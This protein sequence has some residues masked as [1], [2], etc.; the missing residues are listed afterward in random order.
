MRC[1]SDAW[2][3]HQRHVFILTLLLLSGYIA[4]TTVNPRHLQL[5]GHTISVHESFAQIGSCDTACQ[6]AAKVT[7]GTWTHFGNIT[8]QDT[9]HNLHYYQSGS[10]RGIRIVQMKPI[11]TTHAKIDR[12]QFTIQEGWS[13][14]GALVGSQYWADDAKVA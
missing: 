11:N 9:L 13:Q 7:D 2:S 12:R 4:Y 14:E 5:S 8:V 3:P 1:L 6:L 10:R